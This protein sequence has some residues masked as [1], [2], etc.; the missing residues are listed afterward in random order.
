MNS[1]KTVKNGKMTEQNY[2]E[3]MKNIDK[4]I[5]LKNHQ[6]VLVHKLKL[7]VF[8][9]H[10]TKTHDD[11]FWI[12]HIDKKEAKKL[13]DQFLELYQNALEKPFDRYERKTRE[14]HFEN[15][16]AYFIWHFRNHKKELSEEK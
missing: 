7:S 2:L 15:F 3:N 9:Q 12:D 8:A 13:F 11:E 6:M 1:I 4:V 10:L 16:K 14:Y 5:N